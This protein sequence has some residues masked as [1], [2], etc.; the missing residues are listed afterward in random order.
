M[1]VYC[2]NVPNH[3]FLIR[4]KGKICWTGNSYKA[5]RQDYRDSHELINWDYHYKKIDEVNKQLD[6]ATYNNGERYIYSTKLL[7]YFDLEKY[8]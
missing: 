2:I 5:Q 3:I 4:R 8:L 6:E 1:K 7:R